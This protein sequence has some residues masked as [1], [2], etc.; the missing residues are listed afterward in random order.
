MQWI[1]RG[2]DR[3]D[4]GTKGIG[5]KEAKDAVALNRMSKVEDGV[6]RSTAREEKSWS[7]LVNPAMAS[8]QVHFQA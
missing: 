3:I 2:A 8:L 4:T 1:P 6:Q 5:R 7:S